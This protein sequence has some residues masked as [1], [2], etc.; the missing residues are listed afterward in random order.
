MSD[1]IIPTTITIGGKEKNIIN[2]LVQ[3]IDII[4]TEM[5]DNFVLLI[6]F[7]ELENRL[8]EEEKY[9]MQNILN[10]NPAKYGIAAPYL[11]I[12]S[13][14]QD[15]VA[16]RGQKYIW[17]EEEKKI[18]TQYLPK[19]V[20]EAYTKMNKVVKKDTKDGLLVRSG[21][22]SPAYQFLTFVYYF[23]KNDFDIQKTFAQVALPGYSEHGYPPRQAVDFITENGV[24]WGDK[25]CF[26]ETIEYKWLLK[27]AAKY[28]FFL[29]YPQDN[30][31]GMMFEPWHWRY[32][33]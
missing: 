5:S 21:Y 7:E 24:I 8:S 10:I 6:S 1:S 13:V 28:G 30:E 19:N 15:I 26:D 18:A 27:N 3:T 22:R 32:N 2:S 11:G 14:P 25:I 20:Y 12:E 29:S 23:Q 4:K 17:E 16:I 9:L 31:K 33:P